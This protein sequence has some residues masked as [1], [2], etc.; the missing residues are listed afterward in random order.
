MGVAR[1]TF[2]GTDISDLLAFIRSAGRGTQRIYAVPGRPKQG[3]ALFVRKRCVE[4]HSVRGHGGTIGPDLGLKLKGSL[5]RIT[6]AMW[7]HGPQMWARMAERGMEVPS[8]DATEMGD[9]VAYIY[10]F[11][12]IDPPGDVRHGRVVY[13]EKQCALCHGSTKGGQLV[14]PPL[15]QVVEKLATPLD[16]ITRMWNHA[17]RMEERMAEVNVAWP[18]FKGG[19][20]ADLIAY[21]LRDQGGVSRPND[22]KGPAPQRGRKQPAK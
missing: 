6:G 19:E 22:P 11:Q 4:C 16:I 8:L 9:L 12:F 18:I 7:N 17:G 1:P 10:F 13:E 14:A 15:V 2:E 3:E 21:L 20:M 5:M